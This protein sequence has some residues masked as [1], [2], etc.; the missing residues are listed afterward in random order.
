VEL[1]IQ[2]RESGPAR[3]NLGMAPLSGVQGGKLA[4]TWARLANLAFSVEGWRYNFAGLR[5]YKDKF[6]PHWESRFIATPPG[7]GG[8]RSLL[9]LVRLINNSKPPSAGTRKIAAP[10]RSEGPFGETATG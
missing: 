7:L 9:D 2:A 8:W 10:A 1:L 6:A 3:F 5:H 4:P